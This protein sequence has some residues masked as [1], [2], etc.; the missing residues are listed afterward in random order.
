MRIGGSLTQ[1]PLASLVYLFRLRRRYD[2]VVDCENGIPFFSPLYS[3]LPKVLVVHHV[4]QEIFR[5]QLPR[6][7]R[8]FAMWLEGSL[9]PRLYRKA[10]VVAVSQGTS[11]DLVGL[12]F[13]PARITIARNGVV[14]PTELGHSA[15]LR[16]T[17]LCMGRLKPQ[18][19]VDVLI[20]AIPAILKEFPDLRVDIVGQGPDRTR[21][22][23]LAW[24]TGLASH[25][26]F[27]GY[28]RAEVRDQIS[29]E[30]W[31]SV[32]PSSFE[33][34]GVV[35]MEASARGLPVV[36]SNVA[37][38]RES[39]RD[40]ETG[41]LFPYGDQDALAK[42]VV[43]L[44]GSSELRVGMGIAG[45]EWAASHTWEASAS[46]FAELLHAMVGGQPGTAQSSTQPALAFRW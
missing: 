38:L 27:H 4:H 46:D 34:W 35:C 42:A 8:W 30:A 14:P 15:S 22:E 33:G 25:V 18:K 23:R 20:R 7:V 19:S 12:G 2:V 44:L 36:A 10:Q 28:V 3:R 45:R 43:A 40:G 1:Y 16:P 11:D 26:R 31:I 32:C 41:V 39:I 13:D 5:N 37:G 21:L 24:S 17:I 6:Q 9:M 29:A